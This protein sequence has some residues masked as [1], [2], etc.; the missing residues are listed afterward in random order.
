MD[1]G[2][3]LGGGFA[4]LSV[5]PCRLHCSLADMLVRLLSCLLPAY[6]TS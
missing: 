5:C 2:V 6:S 1:E 3:G 4:P